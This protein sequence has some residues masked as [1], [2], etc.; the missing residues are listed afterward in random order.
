LSKLIVFAKFPKKGSAVAG[1]GLSLSRVLL[2]RGRIQ[3]GK[4]KKKV[5]RQERKRNGRGKEEERKREEEER[6]RKGSICGLGSLFEWVSL[7]YR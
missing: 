5:N 3:N 4:G 2:K 6:K 1:G 7:R